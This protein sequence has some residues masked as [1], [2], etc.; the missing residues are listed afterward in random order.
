MTSADDGGPE[1]D[2]KRRLPDAEAV[3]GEAAE[4]MI[5]RIA[6]N[7]RPPGICLTGGSGPKAL[8]TLLGSPD[9]RLRDR[10][11][12]R[13]LVHWGRSVLVSADDKRNNMAMAKDLFLNRCAPPGNIHLYADGR[14]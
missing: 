5:S 13:S 12:P 9:Y 10:R 4:R 1:K 3:A 6:E 7:E 8:Y 14:S 11:G 2:S